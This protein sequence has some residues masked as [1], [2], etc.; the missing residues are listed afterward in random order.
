MQFMKRS[1]DGK[2]MKWTL[3]NASL[4]NLVECFFIE[5]QARK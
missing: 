1:N 4:M 2:I 3:W 5:S